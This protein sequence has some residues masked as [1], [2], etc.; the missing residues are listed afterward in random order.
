M[1]TPTTHKSD[2]CSE[3]VI[4]QRCSIQLYHCSLDEISVSTD[5]LCS[6]VKIPNVFRN[7][8]HEREMRKLRKQVILLLSSVIKTFEVYLG[9]QKE[10][11]LRYYVVMSQYLMSIIT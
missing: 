6:D 8:N 4:I 2:G 3:A 10:A 7:V 1:T 5:L 9:R 11:V